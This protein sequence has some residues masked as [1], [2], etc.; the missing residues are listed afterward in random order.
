[1]TSPVVELQEVSHRFDAR[2]AISDIDLEISEGEYVGLVGPNGGGKTTTLKLILGLLKQTKG[3]VRVFGKPALRLS[4]SEKSHIGFVRQKAWDM[5]PSFPGTVM[6][7]AGTAL[8][9]KI[10]YGRRLK[11]EQKRLIGES[12]EQVGISHLQNNFVRSLSTGQQQ[13]LYLARALSCEPKLLLLDEPTSAVDAKTQSEFFELISN[14]RKERV[15]TIVLVSH[16][17][18]AVAAQVESLA[19]INQDLVFRGSVEEG[20]HYL[21]HKFSIPGGDQ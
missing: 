8:Y 16:D 2:W 19:I 11:R 20:E 1:M 15:I 13:R 12:L 21:A 14:L 10:G 4:R 9:P 5:D 17:L 3:E 18:E 7:V 6:E